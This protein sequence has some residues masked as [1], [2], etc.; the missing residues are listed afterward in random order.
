MHVGYKESQ[1]TLDLIMLNDYPVDDET[2]MAVYEFVGDII[3]AAKELDYKCDIDAQFDLCLNTDETLQASQ[4]A[5]ESL[6]GTV[7]VFPDFKNK[8][9]VA[10]IIHR[11]V[12]RNM[13][14]E[15][16]DDNFIQNQGK[17]YS[18]P[19]IFTKNSVN[20]LGYYLT[21]KL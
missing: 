18:A 13:Q 4:G 11:G 12:I 15:G 10:Y 3:T 14:Q 1:P 19:F 20:T 2:D 16:F 7:A 9:A 21:H 5:I 8:T 17:F 6:L